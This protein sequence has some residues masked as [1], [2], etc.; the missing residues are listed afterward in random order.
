MK[1]GSYIVMYKIFQYYRYYILSLLGRNIAT[2]HRKMLFSVLVSTHHTVSLT[3]Q[4]GYKG[5]TVDSLSIWSTLQ[6]VSW[7]DG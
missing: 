6:A 7:Q 3:R 4:I 2:L 5:E 1:L